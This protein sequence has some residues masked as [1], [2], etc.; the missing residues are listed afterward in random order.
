MVNTLAQGQQHGPFPGPVPSHRHMSGPTGHQG[1]HSPQP[2]KGPYSSELPL[3]DPTMSA[4]TIHKPL[5]ADTWEDAVPLQQYLP[6]QDLQDEIAKFR[7]QKNSIKDML[8]TIKSV[9]ARRAVNDL[10]EEQ[11]E[12]LWEYNPTIQW[13]IA[14]IDVFK[15][16]IKEWPSKPRKKLRRVEV[17][18]KTEPRPMTDLPRGQ[19]DLTDPPGMRP[20]HMAHGADSRL[21]GLW[22]PN[23][24]HTG[25]PMDHNRHANPPPLPG[26]LGR[27]HPS[28]GHGRIIDMG[29]DDDFDMAP[30]PPF[31]PPPPSMGG[32]QRPP[33]TVNPPPPPPPPPPPG[34]PPG[35]HAQPQIVPQQHNP[36]QQPRVVPP[37]FSG[38]GALKHPQT[39]QHQHGQQ[40]HGGN[41]Q[42]QQQPMQGAL[43]GAANFSKAK[44][45]RQQQGPSIQ[46][47]NNPGPKKRRS[48]S[49]SLRNSFHGQSESD[50]ESDFFSGSDSQ[51]SARSV[52]GGTYSM[53][54]RSRSRGRKS[55]K[56][57]SLSRSRGRSHSRS[58]SRS[59]HQHYRNRSHGRD[60]RDHCDR[61]TKVYKE[62]RSH[63]RGRTDIE[64]PPIG[65][66]SSSPKDTTL[67][68]AL[69][70][71]N[72]F[73]IRI[74]NDNDKEREHERMDQLARDHLHREHRRSSHS[75]SPTGFPISYKKQEKLYSGQPMS[76]NSSIGGSST[77]GSSFIENNSSIYSSAGDSVFSEPHSRMH[78]RA[79][80]PPPLPY[81][82]FE[83]DRHTSKTLRYNDY[84]HHHPHHHQRVRDP[85][86]DHIKRPSF[87]SH[88]RH[89]TQIDS[90]NHTHNHNPFTPSHYP[91]QRSSSYATA[92]PRYAQQRYNDEREHDPFYMHEM[93]GALPYPDERRRP[94]A[95]VRRGSLARGREREVDEWDNRTRHYDSRGMP[96]FSGYRHL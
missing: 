73:N 81:P 48:S 65:K 57:R 30:D 66:Y 94:G 51:Y 58:R 14:S 42:K 89:T 15:D 4:W 28:Q 88:R 53:I 87:P 71:Q 74:D 23:H 18:L 61:V 27:P 7:R 45:E 13:T 2:F 39:G 40:Q 93:S 25:P 10:V 21:N 29:D 67:A 37:P 6:L 38:P 90:H 3:L 50:S 60:H 86:D 77:G 72:I 56:A 43:S 55:N 5:N 54:E 79:P 62:K 70:H 49:K 75:I 35:L 64:R 47:V 33:L 84:P 31:H 46:I 59:Q 83:R 95:P 32:Q 41:G 17:V 63:A 34:P 24:H 8:N 96:A 68:G 78:T 92:D 1:A 85:Y 44:P 36:Q 91:F 19:F 20:N 26:P 9:S 16:T 69:P 80:L 12:K 52:E 76:R 82:D 22:L 11:N